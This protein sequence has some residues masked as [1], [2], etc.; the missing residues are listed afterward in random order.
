MREK[1]QIDYQSLSNYSPGVKDF[2][3]VKP[4]HKVVIKE[5]EFPY[6]GWEL[7]AIHIKAVANM[8]GYSYHA[9]SD[10][11]TMSHHIWFEKGVSRF[12]KLIKHMYDTKI[13]FAFRNYWTLNIYEARLIKIGYTYQAFCIICWEIKLF[14]FGLCMFEE[15]DCPSITRLKKR[16]RKIKSYF[17][18]A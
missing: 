7:Q 16:I 14:G 8:K 5:S 17:K 6:R 3:N 18:H 11:E 9:W 1:K 12:K 13:T 2:R 15:N 4:N 10:A